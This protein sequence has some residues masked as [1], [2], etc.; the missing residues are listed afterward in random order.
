[1][2][3]RVPAMELP[4]DTEVVPREHWLS[5][6][7]KQSIFML[8]ARAATM[9]AALPAVVVHGR[10][11]GVVAHPT[12]ELEVQAMQIVSLLPVAV[13]AADHQDPAGRPMPAEQAVALLAAAEQA[14]A[15]PRWPAVVRR[16]AVVL[17]DM[18]AAAAAMVV[19]SVDWVMAE[20]GHKLVVLMVPAAVVVVA[21]MAAAEEQPVAAAAAAAADHPI[22]AEY[23]PDRLHQVRKVATAR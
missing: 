16:V 4:E 20:T 13:E 18:T 14:V 1:M 23:L 12:L 9:V 5:R 8:A 11:F 7:D 19:Q 22:P 3:R 21:I 10:V 15:V 17:Q 2:E 6:P